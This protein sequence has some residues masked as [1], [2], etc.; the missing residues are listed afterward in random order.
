MSDNQ[1]FKD[2]AYDLILSEAM[3]DLCLHLKSNCWTCFKDDVTDRKTGLTCSQSIIA[4][5]SHLMTSPPRLSFWRFSL[6]AALW[7]PGSYWL[8]RNIKYVS[9]C[10]VEMQTRPVIHHAASVRWHGS[11]EV[12]PKI[13]RVLRFLD[14]TGSWLMWSNVSRHH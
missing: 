8:V 1:C 12:R 3:L 7:L 6:K 11:I 9:C 5:S 10:L 4:V 2:E 14:S 13:V